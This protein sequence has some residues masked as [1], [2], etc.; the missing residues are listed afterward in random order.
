MDTKKDTWLTVKQGGYYLGISE[1]AVKKNC[2]AEKYTTKMVAG[3]GGKQYRIALSSLPKEAQNKY[4]AEH[5]QQVVAAIQVED[6]HIPVAENLAAE[7]AQK[8]AQRRAKKEDGLRQF[9]QLPAMKKDHAKAKEL[10][11]RACQQFIRESHLNKS[12]GIEAFC[13]AVNSGE[14]VLVPKLQ[15]AIPERHGI[16][17]LNPNSFK[18]WLY[19]YEALGIIALVDQYGKRAGQSVVE[20]TPELRRYVLGFILNYPHAGGTKIK[21][22]IAA[23]KPELDVVSERSLDRYISQ[24]KTENAQL[25][26]YITHPDKWKNVYMPAYGSHFEGIE[27]LNQ[28]WEMDS[29][30]G[31]W[32]LIDGRHSVLGVID[33]YSRRISFHVSKT[34]SAEAVCLA[35]RKA[36][37]E[38]GVPERIRTDNGK[39]YVSDR[40]TS[41]LVQLEIIQDLCIPF[42][43]EEKGTIER[44]LGTMSHGLLELLPGFAGHSVAQAQQIRGAKS[45]AQRIMTPGEVIEVALTAA[46]LQ[47]TL[48]KWATVIYGQDKHSGLNG[49]TPA[50][51]TSLYN[52]H[53]RRISNERALDVLLSEPAGTR[54]I[55]KKGIRFE[56][57]YYIAP[58]LTT[59]TGKAAT[60]KYDDADIGRLFVYVDHEF[61]CI[62]ECPD[63]TGISRQEVAVVTKAATK[64]AMTAQAKELKEFKKDIAAN[65][66]EVV[67]NHRIEQAEN[68]EFFPRPSKEHNTPALEQ[69]VIAD[70][71][72]RGLAAPVEVVNPE[73][74]AVEQ[75]KVIEFLNA[76]PEANPIEMSDVQR[77]R[78][79][80]R[81]DVRQK[82]GA[83]PL[84]EKEMRFYTSFQRTD[85]FKTFSDVEADLSLKA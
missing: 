23:Q 48:D 61:V 30:P 65:I 58:E 83:T 62:A 5:A 67:I 64:K 57:R 78:H 3:N 14:Q 13:S 45:F 55:G 81:L 49:R 63:I 31:D 28:L 19:D 51:V 39:D 73:Q 68:V 33:L 82:E 38:W 4:H 74:R 10:L 2:L 70:R 77:W 60:L 43:S 36:V 24:W 72:H 76:V 35:F 8:Q 54:N 6:N 7:Y 52:G 66:T 50:Q 71:T 40:F 56:G 53:I 41:A 18:R 15:A 9:A 11:L 20:S 12:G 22:A 34:S 37:L 69:A 26:T 32:L 75:A 79:W 47:D 80:N 16:K 1:R 85:T 29:T 42:A 44:T 59:H 27:R 17:H 46:E 21:Q 84:S 25:W